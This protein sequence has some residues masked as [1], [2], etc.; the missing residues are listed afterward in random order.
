MGDHGHR[1]HKI[2]QTFVGKLE[3]KLP[4]FSMMIPRLLQKKNPFLKE[5]LNQNIN[6]KIYII[7]RKLLIAII[8]RK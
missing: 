7:N 4:L 1:F 8:N 2:R 5:I 3:E 6:S